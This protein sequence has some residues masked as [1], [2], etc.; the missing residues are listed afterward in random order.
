MALK[1]ELV[2]KKKCVRRGTTYKLTGKNWKTSDSRSWDTIETKKQTCG[3]M[4]GI[5]KIDGVKVVIVK[6]GQSYY[7]AMPMKLQAW[8]R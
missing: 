2:G 3:K 7:A 6:K 8:L 5:R 4:V 1:P